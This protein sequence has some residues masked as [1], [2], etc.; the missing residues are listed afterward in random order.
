[1]FDWAQVFQ[2]TSSFS[3]IILC[4]LM[5]CLVNF[6][7]FWLP[8][9]NFLSAIFFINLLTS[10]SVFLAHLVD[11]SFTYLFYLLTVPIVLLL[12]PMLSRFTK[13][14]LLME[15]LPLI[16]KSVVILLLLGFLCISP[17]FFVPN[18]FNPESES[19][20]I[21]TIYFAGHFS[22]IILFIGSSSRYFIPILWQLSKG[23]LYSVG[24]GEDT[25][26]WLRGVWLS[27]SIV[28]LMIVIDFAS[29]LFDHHP[30]W[31]DFIS[32]GVNFLMFILLAFYTLRYC[33]RPH[34]AEEISHCEESAK[35]EK[36][37]L[38][39]TLA[40]DILAKVDA[41]MQQEQLYLDCNISLDKI[42]AITNTQPQY[43]SQAI[44]Q[45]K[46]MNFYEYVAT[47]RIEFAKDALKNDA[48]KT[49]LDIAMSSGFN[50]KSTFN[51]TFKK[52]TGLT[53]SQFKKQ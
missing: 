7:L 12:G 13:A 27:I 10:V 40:E 31:R 44:N 52:I 32:Y 45:Y 1:M 42:A 38:T 30:I 34:Q 51:N 2:L 43:L 11:N 28:W 50:A 20:L 16:D 19:Q 35:Y 37:A 48:D 15:K 26:H 9:K 36:S 22:F 14:T 23:R 5:L 4:V 18:D 46:E 8:S 49:I 17:Y 6:S 21:Q 25:Y 29:D 24:Y 3:I 41:L 33:K 53:P 47:Y 39:S